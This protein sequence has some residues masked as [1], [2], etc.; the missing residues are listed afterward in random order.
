MTRAP[1]PAGMEVRQARPGDVSGIRRVAE[2]SWEADYPEILHRENV[3]EVVS[4]WYDEAR[5]SDELDNGDALVL[6][7]EAEGVV[8]GFGHAVQ[9]RRTGHILRVYVTPDHRGG[10]VG[11][12]LLSALEGRLRE[13]GAERVRAMVLAEN[14]VGNRFYRSAG[15][16][17][18]DED[19]TTIGGETYA[20]NVYQLSEYTG[21]RKP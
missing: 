8:A 13:R 3:G 2:H 6:V 11:R 5:I 19:E 21:R 16:E 7:A 15:F 14:E 9:A 17:K 20:E 10:G 12:D 1:Q 18:I 4:E